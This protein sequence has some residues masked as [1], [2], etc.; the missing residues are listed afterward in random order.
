M[1]DTVI[2]YES[3]V[4]GHVKETA[5]YIASKLDAD[6]FDLKKQTNIN[7]KEYK[8][9]IVGTAVHFGKPLSKV[10]DFV[11]KNKDE[12]AKRKVALFICCLNKNEKGA[13]QCQ[14][15][16]AALN[17]SDASFF[18]DSSEKN[19]SGVSNDADA[20]IARMKA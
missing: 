16:S 19:E 4:G 10:V 11:D 18:P 17:I 6:I 20:F 3:S 14:S 8:R 1:V 2:I 5:Q 15:I 12:L 9:V 13:T 7:M